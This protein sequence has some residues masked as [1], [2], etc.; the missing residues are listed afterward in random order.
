MEALW[1]LIGLAAL[2]VTGLGPLL[3]IA[4]LLRMSRLRKQVDDLQASVSAVE[5]RLS[6]LAGRVVSERPSPAASPAAAVEAAPAFVREPSAAPTVPSPIPVPPPFVMPESVPDAPPT[7]L[8]LR[9]CL[10][11]RARGPRRPG[12]TS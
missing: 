6:A 12:L 8:R 5:T 3:A 11:P 10:C 4:G 1:A 9:S 2:V 7:R